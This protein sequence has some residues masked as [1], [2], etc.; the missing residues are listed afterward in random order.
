VSPERPGYSIEMYPGPLDEFE[1]PM[2]N[3]WAAERMIP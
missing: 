1:F 2:G 3:V